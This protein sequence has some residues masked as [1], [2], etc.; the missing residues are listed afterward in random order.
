M[1]SVLKPKQSLMR[2][3]NDANYME[4]AFDSV[5]STKI[6]ADMPRGADGQQRGY[7]SL[8]NAWN[9]FTMPADNIMF[10]T[11]LSTNE[12]KLNMCPTAKYL[13]DHPVGNRI[14]DYADFVYLTNYGKIPNNR[15]ITLRRFAQ[16]CQND[17]TSTVAMDTPEIARM[18]TYTDDDTNSLQSILSMDFGLKWKPLHADFWS[19]NTA[20][21]GSRFGLNGWMGSIVKYIDPV[22]IRDKALGDRA[23]IN[24]HHD[25]NKVYGPVDS[26][27][28]TYIRDR[29]LEFKQEFS[30]EFKYSIKS[31]DGIDAKAA[32]LDLI[33]NVLMCTYNNAKFWSGAYH[34]VGPRPSSFWSY[35][36]RAENAILADVL[37][38]ST[39]NIANE[40]NKFSEQFQ[41]WYNDSKS[42]GDLLITI[43][44]GALRYGFAELMN[45]IGRPSIPIMNSLLNGDAIGEWHLTIGNPLRPIVCIGNLIC[46]GTKIE[47]MSNSL[48]ID[49]FPTDW[50]ITVNLQHAMPLDKAGIENMFTCG[51]GRTYWVPSLE[52]AKTM[53][54]WLNRKNRTLDINR[55]SIDTVYKLV[56]DFMHNT[57]IDKNMLKNQ[58]N[59]SVDPSLQ[60]AIK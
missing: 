53:Q 2:A 39:S 13:V 12:A 50:K 10:D 17:I 52:D 16:P 57:D 47:P 4:S 3:S 48:G 6:D 30:I 54:S 44:K 49:D 40:F 15:L 36:L 46:T 19:I 8:F 14:Y 24:P 60:K 31:I 42:K 21:Q 58:M 20:N 33:S 25:E 45:K 1:S 18:L 29:G 7:A 32:M 56:H 27:T 41:K 5:W 28:S 37:D 11:D 26:I 38:G 43:A 59:K 35:A 34:W 23:Y 51:K 55:G 22:A 9:M